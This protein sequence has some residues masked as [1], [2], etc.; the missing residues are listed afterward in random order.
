MRGLYAVLK[1]ADTHAGMHELSMTR[2]WANWRR[3]WRASTASGSGTTR[4]C[5]SRPSATRPD[6]TWTTPIGHSRRVKAI[7]LWVALDDATRENGCLY[8]VPGTQKTARYD[9]AGIGQNIGELFNVY[10]EWRRNQPIGS[11]CRAGGAVLHNGLTAHGAG[12]NMTNKPRRAMTCAYMPDGSA[13]NG[14]QNVLPEAYFQ[15]LKPG[16]LLNDNTVNPLLWSK[17]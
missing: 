14:R 15:T 16:D 12:A 4:P 11:P 10:P 6:G 3:H 2:A 1:L 7:S 13:F 9:N 5:S 17:G 8:Y